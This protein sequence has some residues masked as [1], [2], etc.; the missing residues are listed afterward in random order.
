MEVD[1][2]Q[3]L[4]F[5]IK[6]VGSL[7]RRRGFMTRLGFAAISDKHC[8]LA[9]Q[10]ELSCG[11]VTELPVANRLQA[12]QPFSKAEHWAKEAGGE[13]GFGISSERLNDDRLGRRGE[14]LGKHAAM[15][16]GERTWQM[17]KEFRI[18]LAQRPWDLTTIDVEGASEE[19]PD[20]ADTSAEGIQVVDAQE[21]NARAKK[22]IPGG[23]T[24]AHDGQGP[25]PISDEPLDG[26]AAGDQVT[27]ANS[28]HLKPPLKL[29]RILRINDRGWQSA[30]MSAHSLAHGFDPIASIT[31]TEGIEALVRVALAAGIACK[32]LA[33][34]PWSQQQKDPCQRDD[35]G[36]FESPYQV[37]YKPHLYPVRLI[38]VKSEGQVKRA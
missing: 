10:A 12:P 34:M 32:P 9:A 15:L 29:D 3:T 22:A 17:A 13:E 19:D 31:W 4:D 21:G 1:E 26:K 24:V 5:V 18:G 38:V 30:Q 28:T 16:Q 27:W 23:L 11:P 2:L 37:Y 20:N 33:Y 35:Y 6:T 25:I 14:L 7:P 36:A 8:P